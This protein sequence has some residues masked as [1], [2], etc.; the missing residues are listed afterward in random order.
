MQYALRYFGLWCWSLAHVAAALDYHSTSDHEGFAPGSFADPAKVTRPRFRYWLPDASVDP[1]DVAFDIRDLGNHGAGG[2]ELHN[3]YSSPTGAPPTNWTTYGYGTPAFVNI[4]RAILQTHIDEG[5]VPDISM[6]NNGAIPAQWDNPDLSWALKTS[7]VVVNG[8]YNGTLPGWGSGNFL[9]AHTY[10][11]LNTSTIVKPFNG[12]WKARDPWPQHTISNESLTVVSDLVQPDGSIRVTPH[13]VEGAQSHILQAFYMYQPLARK[14]IAAVDPPS[15][16]QN[17]SLYVDHFSAKG[18]RLITEFLEEHILAD[19]VTELLQQVCNY[20]WEDSLEIPGD[21]YWT[22]GLEEGFTTQY[23]YDILRYLPL[24]QTIG[25][26]QL[27][28]PVVSVILDSGDKG[29]GV[30]ADFLSTLTQGLD[31]YYTY[32]TQWT[33]RKLGLKFSAQVGYNT[34]VDMLQLVPSVDAPESESLSFVSDIDGYTQY[35]TPAELSGKPVISNEMGAD[36][37]T[38]FSQTWQRVL[39]GA[40]QAFA[41][42][43]NQ[44]VLHG[45]TFSHNFTETTWPGYITHKYD[46]P[47]YSRHQPGWEVGFQEAMNYLGRN[48]W[49]LQSGVP[50]IDLVFWNKQMPQSPYPTSIYLPTDLLQAGY[51]YGY[52]SPENFALPEAYAKSGILA[53]TRQAFKLLI[54]RGNDT[55]TPQGVDYLAKYA[56]QGLPIVISGGVPSRYA[57]SNQAAIEKA[58]QTLTRLLSFENVHQV[59]YENLAASIASLHI[60][61]RS[62]IRSNGTWHTRWRDLPTKDSYVFVYNSGNYSAGS[63]TFKHSGTAYFLDAWTGEE[64]QIAQYTY[65]D[66]YLTI[67]LTLQREETR[68]IRLSPS[69]QLRGHVVAAS[70]AVLGVRVTNGSGIEV[71]IAGSNG[72]AEVVLSSGKRINKWVSIPPRSYSIDKWQVKVEQWLPPDDFYNLDPTSKKV[73][74][75]IDNPGPS[76]KS[77]LDLGLSNVSGIGYYSATIQWR[78]Q[79]YLSNELGAY[80]VL[81]SISHGVVGFINGRKLPPFDITNPRIDI[82]SYLVHGNNTIDLRASSTLWNGVMPYWDDI[83]TAGY[84]VAKPLKDLPPKQHYGIIGDVIIEP[85]VRYTII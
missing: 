35:S 73:N 82:T 54:L 67:P 55:L 31:S 39:W 22:P 62:Q 61:P 70:D 19:G 16:L 71:Q 14:I 56:E 21:I 57:T 5:L 15:F 45:A 20:L 4:L 75:T 68:L 13:H 10:A 28:Q 38:P 9:A 72:T 1:E 58:N 43:V 48:S 27:P 2:I 6:V 63:I 69:G 47:E 32:L 26:Y 3:G 33:H 50:K 25:G 81:P 84:G 52:L 80:L 7:Q 83:R 34:P 11:I 18:A 46:Y 79:P 30:V 36:Y 24:L 12:P 23:A 41:G 77:W 85:Y 29:A 74:I 64:I 76:L 37:K 51:T 40:K 8:S 44:L 59:P 60:E 66:G 49:A 65:E 42:G 78:P 17:G 53:P